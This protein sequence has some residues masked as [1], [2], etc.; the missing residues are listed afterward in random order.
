MEVLL[1][2]NEFLTVA[3]SG[4]TTDGREILKEDLIAMED[5]YKEKD[6]FVASINLGHD[7]LYGA[8]NAKRHGNI[9]EVR[10]LTE[11]NSFQIKPDRLSDELRSELDKGHYPYLSIVIGYKATGYNDTH[12]L[13]YKARL[14]STDLLGAMAPAIEVA[15][16]VEFSHKNIADDI[17]CYTFDISTINNKN[18]EDT[19]NMET[20]PEIITQEAPVLTTANTVLP[21]P[22]VTNPTNPTTYV[23]QKVPTNGTTKIQSPPIQKE[24]FH[25]KTPVKDTDADKIDIL[26]KELRDE[27]IKSAT[28][29]AEIEHLSTSLKS[30]EITITEQRKLINKYSFGAY[31]YKFTKERKLK[32][33]EIGLNSPDNIF[34][35]D[36]YKDVWSKITKEEMRKHYFNVRECMT[37]DRLSVPPIG[38][39]PLKEEHIEGRTVDDTIVELARDIAKERNTPYSIQ[40][41]EQFRQEAI[42]RL[43]KQKIL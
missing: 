41:G 14:L 22:Q 29:N 8:G 33:S 11:S 24:L 9:K 17:K 35:S 42:R 37:E 3:K 36:F 7:W 32:N 38:N 34:D 12:N 23:E 1:K 10:Y 4:M 6:H 21:Q 2:E 40:S 18:K 31:Y 16:A 39:K 5:S 43:Q 20:T 28:L 13:R 15:K 19:T 30:T 27:R 26:T 25:V